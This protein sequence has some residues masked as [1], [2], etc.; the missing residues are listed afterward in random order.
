MLYFILI[1]KRDVCMIKINNKK[2]DNYYTEIA[3]GTFDINSYDEKR[4]GN[5]PFITFNLENNIF[6][7]LELTFP[8]KGFKKMKMNI[9]TNIN[10]Y[11]SDITYE[12]EKGWTSL[13][14][15][16][17]D[18]NIT[19]TSEKNFIIEFYSISDELNINIDTNITLL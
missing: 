3:W 19:K 6:I 18:C 14:T 9:K 10:N 7:G 17:Y 11:V 4:T 1:K 12:D 13:I 2:Y 15:K 5:S 16:K 8:D